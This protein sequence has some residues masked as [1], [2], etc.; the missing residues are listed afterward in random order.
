MREIEVKS[1][2]GGL[3]KSLAIRTDGKPLLVVLA[4]DSFQ[5]RAGQLSTGPIR[6]GQQVVDFDPA[7]LV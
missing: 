6:G 2:V 7:L 5:Q 4:D 3:V 1:Y